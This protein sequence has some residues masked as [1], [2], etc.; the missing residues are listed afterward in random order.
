MGNG[1]HSLKGNAVLSL[2]TSSSL[3]FYYRIF[4]EVFDCSFLI[5][6][7]QILIGKISRKNIKVEHGKPFLES[8]H[9]G[10]TG[11]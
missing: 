2:F 11:C 3:R 7:L 6:K 4:R 1:Q 10:G 5:A 8:Q 9:F